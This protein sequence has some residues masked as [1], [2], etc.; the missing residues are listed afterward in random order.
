MHLRRWGVM[1]LGDPDWTWREAPAGERDTPFVTQAG[2][3]LDLIEGRPAVLCTLEDAVQTL[4]FNLAALAS[5]DG[6]GIRIRC[7]DLNA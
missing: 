1:K 3:F 2:R 6:G 5:A 7:A 4:R